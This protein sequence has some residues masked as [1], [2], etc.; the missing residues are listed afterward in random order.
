[1]P[2]T[3]SSVLALD[4]GN[5]RVGIALASLAARLPQP[6]TTLERGDNFLAK[7]SEI[8]NHEDV[9]EIVVGWPR[10][11]EGQST[12][13]TEATAAFV[14]ELNRHFPALPIHQQDEALTSKMA[15]AELQKRGK[16]YNRGDVDALAASYILAD[17]LAEH[18]SLTGKAA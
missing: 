10:G 5:K 12:S 4:V 14:E 16:A 2:A 13:Q 17:W 6:L 18:S 8:I 1:M 7:L 11:L 15:E 9:S 3:P